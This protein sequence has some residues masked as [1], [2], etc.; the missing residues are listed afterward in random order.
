MNKTF[1]STLLTLLLL[2]SGLIAAAQDEFAPMLQ[3]TIPAW[4][5]GKG[6][7]MVESNIH[8]PKHACIY[9]YTSNNV[10]VYKETIEGV[11]LHLNKPATK[12]KLKQALETIIDSKTAGGSWP[13]S[14]QV[15][16]VLFKR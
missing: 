16:A 5:S 12:M 7:W 1:Q 11:N 14:A 10:L 6:Y 2:C 9:F 3:P 15:V 4:V 8:H 13:A